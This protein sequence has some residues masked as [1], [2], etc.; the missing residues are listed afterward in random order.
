[1]GY[2]CSGKAMKKRKGNPDVK[3]EEVK[4][5]TLDKRPR[6]RHGSGFLL[7]WKGDRKDKEDSKKK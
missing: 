1:M 4:R 2:R 5:I 7:D 3:E 6:R